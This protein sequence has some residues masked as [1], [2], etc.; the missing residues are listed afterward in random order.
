MWGVSA[1]NLVALMTPAEAG[2]RVGVDLYTYQTKDGRG[3]RRALDYLTPYA[4]AGREWPHQQIREL[5]NARR[6]LA[7]LLRRA[8]VAYRE[9]K[10][11]GLLEKHLAGAAAQ[12][13]WQL[14]WPR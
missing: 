7:Y 9:P 12:Q 6:D 11:V 14:L 13:R 10:Y 3:D 1:F 4:D 8:S 5:E 2:K